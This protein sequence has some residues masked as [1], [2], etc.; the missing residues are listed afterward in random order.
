MDEWGAAIRLE[1]SGSHPVTQ[2]G[3]RI[4]MYR[5]CT[6]KNWKILIRRKFDFILKAQ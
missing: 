3:L 1:L 2:L 5:T 4:T 6:Y